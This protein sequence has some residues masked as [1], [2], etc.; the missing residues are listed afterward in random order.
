MELDIW[1]IVSAG[2]GLVAVVAGGFYA[3]VKG[4][5]SSIIALGKEA[6]DLAQVAVKSLDD[7][8]I[9]KEEVEQI[10]KEALEV[11]SAWRV[12]TGKV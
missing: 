1:T 5:L 7:N 3:K 12:L 10:K 2:L 9:T 8:K 11:R 4:K 6:V